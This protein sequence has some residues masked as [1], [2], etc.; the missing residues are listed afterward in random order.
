MEKVKIYQ[1]TKTVIADLITPVA[2]YMSLRDKF[3]KPLLLESADYHDRSDSKSFICLN[4]LAGIELKGKGA[5]VKGIGFEFKKDLDSSESVLALFKD[6]HGSFD[7]VYSNDSIP[8]GGL[9]G[10][11]SFEA[12]QYFEDI[13]MTNVPDSIKDNP[14]LMYHF[15]EYVLVFDHFKNE[16]HLV[17]HTVDSSDNG[18]TSLAQIENHI[19]CHSVNPFG[20]QIIGEEESPIEDEQYRDY[21][22]KGIHHCQRGDVF[23]VVLSRSF[24]QKFKGDEFCVYRALRRLNPSPYLFYF[25]YGDFKIFGSS[26]EAQILVNDNKAHINP[27]AGTVRRGSDQKEDQL[28]AAHLQQ[29]PKENAEHVM[30]VDLARNDL[31]KQNGR[32]YVDSY[33]EIQYFSHVIHMVSKVTAE[34]DSMQNSLQLFADTFPAGTLSGAPKYRALQI[35]NE[36]E[37]HTR[38]FYGGSI[39]YFGFDGTINHAII[40][41]SA[42]SKNNRLCYQAGAGIVVDSSPQGELE[43][44]NN[45]VAALRKAIQNAEQL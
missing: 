23:Q 41:R 1:R 9:F 14:D 17:Y 40:I 10:Y 29:D 5:K 2:L 26:P 39:G 7:Y 18:S 4:P 28:K 38:N 25:D 12:V 43:E 33:G 21:V 42:L 20:F 30:L 31:S 8:T 3:R 19:Q 15:F 34:L 37:A 45:K 35:I 11:T 27:I 32:V 44:V 24:S 36:N 22:R 13:E 6:F 16:L